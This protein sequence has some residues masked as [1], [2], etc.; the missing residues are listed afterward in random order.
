MFCHILSTF[1]LFKKREKKNKILLE[2]LLA[3]F[4]INSLI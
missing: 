2:F 3:D 4:D 1:I